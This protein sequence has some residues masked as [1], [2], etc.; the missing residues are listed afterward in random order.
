MAP[1][2]RILLVVLAWGTLFDDPVRA[3]RDERPS[4]FF[5]TVASPSERMEFLRAALANKP[6]AHIQD[7]VTE[8]TQR[9]VGFDPLMYN[10]AY[11]WLDE[12]YG[13]PDFVGVPA[14]DA[15]ETRFS[16]APKPRPSDF[17]ASGPGSARLFSDD[18]LRLDGS[19]TGRRSRL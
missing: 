18:F 15:A 5:W 11:D 7:A 10:A 13:C 8:R 17:V 19:Q 14:A 1:M 12:L 2:G 16:R 6:W 3:W 9:G 4:G